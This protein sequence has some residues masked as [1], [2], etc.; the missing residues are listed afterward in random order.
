M[1][2][3]KKSI[4]FSIFFFCFTYSLLA[5]QDTILQRIVLIG[6]AGELTK[7][8]HPVVDAI[9]NN[10]KLDKKTTILFLG[11]NL[12]D[13]GLPDDQ[14][15]FYD[16]ARAV[17]DSQLSVADNTP[18]KIYMI[19]GNH[20]WTNGGRD[21]YASII[22]EQLYVDL[23]GKPNVKFYPEDGCPGPV[24][25]S[26]GDDVTIIIFDS[27]WW[28]HRYD[29][30][31][32][33]SDCQ[34][35]TTDELITQI[36][37]IVTRNSK[38][39]VLIAD[40]HPFKS[41]SVH[42][43]FYPLKQHIFPFTD[44]KKNLYIPLPIL[45]SI[46]P[47][48]RSVFGTPQDLS[49]PAYANMI[50]EVTAAVKSHPHIVFVAGH[51][52]GLQWIKDSSF[53]YIV[54]GGGSKTNRVS[55]SKKSPYAS[56]STGF[57]VMEVSIHKNVTVSFYTVEGDSVKHAFKGDMLNFSKIPE[58]KKDSTARVI[59]DPFAKYKDTIS[60]SASE[61][62]PLIKGM[63]R[64]II[65]QNYRSEWS[66][67]VNMKVFNITNA[68][69]TITGLGGGK[70]TK[71]LR[72]KDKNG[73]EW[74]MRAIDKNP[75]KALPENFRGTL[76]QDLV[77]EFNSASNPYGALTIP[78]LAAPLDV[79]VP[80]PQLFFIPDDPALGF[81]RPLFA[82]TVCLLE[83]RDAS[84]DGSD[85]KSTAK[86][87]DKLVEE[88]DHRADQPA[89]L[90]ARLLDILIGDFDRHFDQ[91]KW[92]T[93]DTGKGKLYYPIPRDRDQAYF[94]SD[95]ALLKFASRNLLPFLR[96]FRNDIQEVNWLSYS[97][98][99]FDRL[100]LT[101]LDAKEWK[102]T[103]DDFQLAL[104][105]SVLT[106]AIKRLPP[107]IYAIDG[108]TIVNK[109]K[110]RRNALPVA[111]MKY[112]HFISR[113]VNVLGSNQKEYFKVSNT[114]NG[115]QVRVY[116]REKGN[117]TSFLM[118]N[119][120]FEPKNTYE[121]RLYGLN[122]DDIF[123]IDESAKSRIKIRIIGG[124]G[125]D[126]FDIRGNVQTLLYDLNVEGNYI[127]NHHRAKVRFSNDPPVNSNRIPVY[128]YNK[129]RFPQLEFGVNS[130][131]GLLV[132]AGFS[133]TTHGFR[134]DPYS[135]YQKFS[136]LYSLTRGAYRF[137]YYGEFNHIT[138][139]IDVILNGEFAYPALK[140][141][142]GLGNTT[143]VP[144][145]PDYS[146]Y[147]SRSRTVTLEALLR[148]RYF[149]KLQ[150][151]AGPYFQYYWNN[152]KDNAG[153]I[154]G[155]PL[156][157]GL[158]SADIYSKKTYLGAKVAMNFDNRNNTTFPT[159]GI[160]W[161]NELVSAAGISKGSNNF[162]RFSTD[163][164]IYA[165]LSDPARIVAVL[166]LGGGKIFNQSFEYFQAMQIGGNNL[167]G[168]RR[169]RFLGQSSMYGSLELRTKLFDVKSYLFPGPFGLTT[170]YDVGRVWL[171]NESSRLWHTAIGGGFY[172]IPFNMLMI[173]A[174]V[175]FSR[176]ERLFN[177]SL[178]SKINLS[179]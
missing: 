104:N 147:R 87:F 113:Q 164:T 45:G 68:G 51:D 74:V 56:E 65:G 92:A 167:H 168:F 79:V 176:Q 126:T 12:Y 154:L 43:G 9:R 52:H 173:S 62:Y 66:A 18:A 161:N 166:G 10:I 28:I 140:N 75:T 122:D 58:E 116:A 5:Q 149:E 1:T 3:I 128:Q 117:D 42:G 19:P 170:F 60:I 141:F 172:F 132:G 26:L 125:N 94:Y 44:M 148:K 27:Q 178:G 59:D 157:G 91:W 93:N 99:D 100:F 76:A 24:E 6:D 102:T 158:D 50:H 169:N 98:K 143:K 39:L 21:G 165:S 179:F 119:R 23:L 30:P 97:A 137:N 13:S 163:M 175:G 40:H 133:R 11:D 109:L 80:H 57:A 110:A 4:G 145:T 63:K 177:F 151:M 121:I 61:K 85:T 130:D 29:K 107:E 14:S 81:Y 15:N 49:H 103:I 35:K 84:L 156:F 96:G 139:D 69:Y 144:S 72:L 123:D 159:R 115:L 142:F 32:I 7:G 16:S 150:L 34:C 136:G 25:V 17:L 71:S 120:T 70:Q 41:N 105:D 138:R 8:R 83:E 160:L 82:N 88:N 112:Y 48:A 162:T 46:Y 22:R 146:F 118:Y 54:S 101:D 37:D 171:K 95:G 111:A 47:I 2:A 153:R 73:K 38:K 31:G 20:D 67:P 135:T 155:A 106:H 152:Y 36:Q 114:E 174:S 129:A 90:R 55:K 89:V 124:K 131:D 53:N 78:G 77:Q 134:N 33:E 108:E 64:F 86:V 127:K